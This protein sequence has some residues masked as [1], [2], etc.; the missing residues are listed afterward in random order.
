LIPMPIWAEAL[1]GTM[2]VMASEQRLGPQIRDLSSRLPG[3]GHSCWRAVT[4]VAWTWP[5]CPRPVTKVG[6]TRPDIRE[7]SS[8]SSAPGPHI[9]DPSPR[10]SGTAP[11]SAS[12]HP[13]ERRDPEQRLAAVP[14]HFLDSGVRRS[15][16]GNTNR[17]SDGGN[18]IRRSDRAN[19]RRRS[20][21]GNNRHLS[22]GANN[23]RRSQGANQP[24]PR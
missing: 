3:I 22:D 11:I 13:G 4:K 10:S 21:G 6:C 24:V 15:D 17:R 16:G 14:G 2:E 5:P 1:G 23:R 9:R 8:R 18:T 20:D 7:P 19:N 12:R